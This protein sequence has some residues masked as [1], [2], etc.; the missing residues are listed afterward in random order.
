MCPWVVNIGRILNRFS[1]DLGQ[2]EETLPFFIYDFTLVS[3]LGRLGNI[4]SRP[5]WL[6]NG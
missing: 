1:K 4:A 2:V 5:V 6:H 3:I